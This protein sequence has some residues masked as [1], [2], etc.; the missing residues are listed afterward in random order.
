MENKVFER[1]K[2]E[3]REKERRE[4]KKIMKMEMEMGKIMVLLLENERGE[5]MIE[6]F[7]I[8]G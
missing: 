8:M 7:K 1:D 2:Y 3:K 6:R 4:V 5:M